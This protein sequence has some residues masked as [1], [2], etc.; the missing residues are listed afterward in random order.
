MLTINPKEQEFLE[1]IVKAIVSEPNA[2][3]IERK[4]DELGVLYTLDVALIDV[5][6]V[7]GRDGRIAQAIRLLLKV[8]GFGE[9]VR[10]N[11]K[12][13]A[14]RIEKNQIEKINV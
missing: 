2:V 7:I 5:P 13:N 12:I 4:V 9:K 8:V 11:L 6:K 10:A 1:Y 3:K 14:P